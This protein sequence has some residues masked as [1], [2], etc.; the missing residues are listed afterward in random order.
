MNKKIRVVSWNIARRNDPWRE[1]DRMARQGEADVALLQEAGS[2]PGDLIHLVP[3]NDEDF[4]GRDLYN[5]W[6][7]VVQLSDRVKIDRFRPVSPLSEC[8]EEDIRVSD[9]RTIAAAR[10]TRANLF[11]F[12]RNGDFC[13]NFQ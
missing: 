5:R 9:F 12:P 10:V 13:V 3:H 7:A 1:L 4:Q 8:G 2:P 6:P 11:F